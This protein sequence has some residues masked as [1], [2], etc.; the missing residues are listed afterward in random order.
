MRSAKVSV[1]ELRAL[2]ESRPWKYSLCC[3]RH[4]SDD[5]KAVSRYALHRRAD[6]DIIFTATISSRLANLYINHQRIHLGG[7]S[8]ATRH[9]LARGLPAWSG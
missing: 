5:K 9:K 8:E 2:G 7:Q 3:G 6:R 1:Q 4:H